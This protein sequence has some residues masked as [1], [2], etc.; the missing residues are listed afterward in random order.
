MNEQDSRT[1]AQDG[2][3]HVLEHGLCFGHHLRGSPL[4]LVLN[5]GFYPVNAFGNLIKNGR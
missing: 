5:V 1:S 4:A 3:F 2:I